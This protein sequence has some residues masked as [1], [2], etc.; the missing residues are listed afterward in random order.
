MPPC[1]LVSVAAP[2]DTKK[3]AE[4][5]PQINTDRHRSEKIPKP[6]NHTPKKREHPHFLPSLEF[7][8]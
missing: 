7:G 3:K 6:N 5:Q 8:L 2:Q 4:E 1:V